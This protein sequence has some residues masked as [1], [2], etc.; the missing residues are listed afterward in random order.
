MSSQP[1]QEQKQ[2]KEQKNDSTWAKGRLY[3]RYNLEQSL[4]FAECVHKLG[5]TRV[6]LDMV[7]AQL[8]KSKDNSTFIGRTSSTRQFNLVTLENGRL[9]LS[10]IGQRIFYPTSQ[11]DK[12]AA[13]QEAF[14]SP[15]LYQEII[16][17]YRGK[18]LPDR[19][20]LG[21]ILKLDYNIQQNARDNAASNFIQSAELLGLIKNGIF[22]LPDYQNI[23]SGNEITLNNNIAE[24]ENN[25]TATN[26]TQD[27]IQ[28]APVVKP[29]QDYTSE[30]FFVAD[31]RRNHVFDYGGGITLIIPIDRGIDES[32]Q[33][34]SLKD[35]KTTLKDL[36]QQYL[37]VKNSEIK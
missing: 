4:E 2:E 8:G 16:E 7:A 10:N 29:S 24:V 1:N 5:G 13:K 36:A 28:I 14:C 35:V 33:D 12:Q 6:T 15:K 30:D 21:N 26:L 3:P 32:I 20:S 19:T 18:M 25:N 9:S 27:K 17:N 22:A 31:R 34:G 23:G 11:T 37:V